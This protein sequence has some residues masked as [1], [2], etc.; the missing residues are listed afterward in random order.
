MSATSF[1]GSRTAVWIVSVLSAVVVSL[2]TTAASTAIK[3]EPDVDYDAATEFF[4]R[5]YTQVFDRATVDAVWE[6]DFTANYR[7]FS[8]RSK[9]RYL[10]RYEVD[11][12]EVKILSLAYVNGRGSNQFLLTVQ[13]RRRNGEWN[14][15]RSVLVYV[16]CTAQRARLP[17]LSCPSDHVQISAVQSAD[18]TTLT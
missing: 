8:W 12:R 18:Q 10:K 16:D 2:I 7:T 14:A 9:E 15:V 17:I 13:A 3:S 1:R 4:H 11:L 6:R 5:H